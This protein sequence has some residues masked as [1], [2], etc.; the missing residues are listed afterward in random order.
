[1]REKKRVDSD[2]VDIPHS[3]AEQRES[4]TNKSVESFNARGRRNEANFTTQLQTLQSF[5]F[6]EKYFEWKQKSES[7]DDGPLISSHLQ[8]MLVID[9]ML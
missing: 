9:S 1:M 8:S 4:S 6:H 2:C 7:V 3:I 5:W